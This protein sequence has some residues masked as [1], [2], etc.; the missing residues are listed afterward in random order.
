ML[1]DGDLKILAKRHKFMQ[2]HS[3]CF[4]VKI[5]EH[6]VFGLFI[7]EL[8]VIIKDQLELGGL[9]IFLV[10]FVEVLSEHCFSIK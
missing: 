1:L 6:F 5:L 10:F 2:I 4:L 9:S 7:V 8:A 3:F